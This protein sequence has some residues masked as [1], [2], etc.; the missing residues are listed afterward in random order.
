MR[1]STIF[2]TIGIILL[3]IFVSAIFLIPGALPA[4]KSAFPDIPSGNSGTT[5]GSTQSNESH[6]TTNQTSTSAMPIIAPKPDPQIIKANGY[7][8]STPS[9]ML[10]WNDSQFSTLVQNL[11]ACNVT[12]LFFNLA[13][14]NQSGTISE[15]FTLD[16]MLILRF[17]HFSDSHS[18][19]YVAWTGTQNDPNA[20]LGNFT[21]AG[22]DQTVTSTYKAGFDGFL[23][24]I[25]PVPNDNQQ[26]LAMLQDFRSAINATAP[27]MLLGV[28]NMNVYQYAAYR[29][30]WGWDKTYFQNVTK[31]LNFISPMLF[32]S[33]TTN[34][35]RYIEY[36]IQ[37]TT[38]VARNSMAPVIFEI[39][40][41]YGPNT[42]YHFP[43]A[44]NISNA[45]IG[46][47][48]YLNLS[49]EGQVPPLSNTLGLAIYGLNKTYALEPGTVSQALDT[50][51]FD[52]SFFVSQWVNAGYPQKIGT[53]IT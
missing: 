40:D 30:L 44:E 32:E 17:D 14:M 21:I 28:N 37:Q 33:G 12:Y 11:I 9:A 13:N 29:K 1:Y 10:E 49:S 38:I 39:P 45:I 2:A 34:S 15:N 22:I 26:F 5:G 16:T 50:K 19:Q 41:W 8:L 48:E 51:P 31:L 35:T 18:F 6:Q 53:N 36:V 4:H 23:I 47:Q 27:G 3:L 20:L 43:L 7:L 46:F 24:D 52:W 25:E 42:T